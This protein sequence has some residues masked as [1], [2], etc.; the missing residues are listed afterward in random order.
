MADKMYDPLREEV[1][2][3]LVEKPRGRQAKLAEKLGV[4]PS[5]INDFKTGRNDANPALRRQIAEK[6]NINY[7]AYVSQESSGIPVISYVSA[8]ESFQWTDQGYTSGDGFDFIDLPPGAKYS[9]NLYAVR[10][11]G[12][13][14]RP[15]LKDGTTLIVKPES[16]EEIRHEDVVV[17]KDE[18]YCAWVKMVLFHNDEIIFRSINSE[19]PDIVKG[20][21]EIILMDLVIATVR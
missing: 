17:W 12:D 7:Y 8:G 10:V 15:W 6:L 11:K 5:Q 2:R 9:P 1:K 21:D 3:R 20:S 18:D 16:R 13:S 4:T 14:M 19:Y